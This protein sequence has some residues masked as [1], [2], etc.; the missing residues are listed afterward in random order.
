MIRPNTSPVKWPAAMTVAGRVRTCSRLV[1]ARARFGLSD[2]EPIL[3]RLT[4]QRADAGR[5]DE[6]FEVIAHD[7]THEKREVKK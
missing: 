5:L 2:L 4:E 3:V 6:P 7:L 1:R